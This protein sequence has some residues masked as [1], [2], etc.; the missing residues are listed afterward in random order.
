MYP[1][2]LTQD[3]KVLVVGAGRASKIK[4]KSLTQ[5]FSDITCLSLNFDSEIDKLN[6]KKI[7]DNFYNLN[8]NFF[9]EFNMIYFTFEYPIESKKEKFLLNVIEYLKESNKL[10]NCSSK[11]K[12]GNFINPCTRRDKN[13]ILSIS[14]LNPKKSVKLANKLI[15][16][17]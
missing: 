1:I 15:K 8:L 5:N 10:L 16:K 13:T 11:P 7:K 4:L 17:I 14:T 12:L 6:I 9:D 3:F 2:V